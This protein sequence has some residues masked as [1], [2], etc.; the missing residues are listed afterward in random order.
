M[1]ILVRPSGE[2]GCNVFR[3]VSLKSTKSGIKRAISKPILGEGGK[4]PALV[5]FLFLNLH[6]GKTTFKAMHNIGLHQVEETGTLE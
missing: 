4:T 5:F 6:R 2:E 1:N 3:E